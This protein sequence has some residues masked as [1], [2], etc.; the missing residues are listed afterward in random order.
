MGV[1]AIILSITTTYIQYS[2]YN[3]I[4]AMMEKGETQSLEGKIEQYK[5]IDIDNHASVESFYLNGV[6]FAYSDYHRIKGYHHA[7][8][9][10]GAICK[11]NQ[12]VKIEYY[13]NDNLNYIVKIETLENEAN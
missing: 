3:K 4:V 11:D 5:P 2:E 12:Q 8:K 1:L 7:C 6:R 10:G 13:T 9:L